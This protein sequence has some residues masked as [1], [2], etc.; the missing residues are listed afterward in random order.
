M[1]RACAVA[2]GVNAA[3]RERGCLRQAPLGRIFE[4]LSPRRPRDP[5]IGTG[6]LLTRDISIQSRSD[7]E[8]FR[9]LAALVRT[10]LNQPDPPLPA[11]LDT[12]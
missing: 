5:C 12:S 4:V 10:S 6:H 7:M 1:P 11:S 8:N 2:E 9:F 3:G